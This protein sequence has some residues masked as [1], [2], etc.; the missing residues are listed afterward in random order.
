MYLPDEQ[1]MSNEWLMYTEHSRH[2]NHCIYALVFVHR[3]AMLD[4]WIPEEAASWAY[5]TL[6]DGLSDDEHAA[7]E[8]QYTSRCAVSSLG[9]VWA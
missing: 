4:K 8:A 1:A 3:A 6:H 2:V 7:K 9:Q 5:F